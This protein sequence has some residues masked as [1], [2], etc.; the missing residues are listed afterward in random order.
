MVSRLSQIISNLL[1]NA[2][3]YTDPSGEIELIGCVQDGMLCLS[4]KDN[5]IGINPQSL[6]R[7]FQM[8]SQVEAA[9]ARLDGGLGIGLALVNGLVAL[10]RG[11]I[12]AS[13]D[14]LGL[15]SEFR[16]RIPL[17]GDVPTPVASVEAVH[18]AAS[19]R[20]VLLV[21]DNKDAAD[22]LAMLL[23]GFDHHLTKPVELETL[24]RLLASALTAGQ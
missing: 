22:A 17:Q 6:D 7:I 8:F 1:T 10:H 2:A 16:I 19:R 3:K 13:S 21:D 14:G 20:R 9:L 4:V 11:T 24:E 18:E 23:A 15:G 5:G 12:E